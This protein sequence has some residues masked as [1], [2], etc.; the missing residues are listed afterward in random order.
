M[1]Q[2]Q[3][4][5]QS[6]ASLNWVFLLLIW[7]SYQGPRTQ[8][9]LVFTHNWGEGFMPFPKVL[10]E[11]ETQTT[12]SRIWTWVADFISCDNLIKQLTLRGNKYRQVN[13]VN[14]RDAMKGELL[15]IDLRFTSQS[16][17]CLFGLTFFYFDLNFFLND[18]SYSFF[19]FVVTF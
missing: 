5:K 1:M 13:S 10:A 15:V 7:L 11:S 18:D 4:V 19:L 6:T 14:P 16:S 3:F 2:G 8:S 12:S 17:I 9:V